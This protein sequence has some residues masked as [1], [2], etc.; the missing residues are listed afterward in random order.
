MCLHKHLYV[1]SCYTLSDYPPKKATFCM[2][3]DGGGPFSN[4]SNGATPFIRLRSTC[5]KGGKA[6]RSGRVDVRW[7]GSHL[8]MYL[9]LLPYHRTIVSNCLSVF[10]LSIAEIL[11]GPSIAEPPVHPDALGTC[12]QSSLT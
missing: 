10:A 6:R 2:G 3:M 1:Q 12:S 11:A 9:K 5:K 8:S 7:I 4:H